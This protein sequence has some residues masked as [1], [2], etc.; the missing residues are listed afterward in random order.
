MKAR[1]TLLTLALVAGSAAAAGVHPELHFAEHKDR[2]L[3]LI[4]QRQAILE[5]E[6]SCVQAAQSTVGLQACY[7]QAT[8]ARERMRTSVVVKH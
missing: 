5:Q 4:A 1:L 8:A 7:V 2:V 3:V 6:K